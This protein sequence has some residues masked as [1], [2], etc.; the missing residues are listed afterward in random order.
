M[1]FERKGVVGLL[2]GVVLG[3]LVLVAGRGEAGRV[4]VADC[5]V[6]TQAQRCCERVARGEA[7]CTFSAA[8]CSSMTGDGRAAYANACL[9]FLK[10]VQGTWPEPP[11]ECR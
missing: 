6:C 9:T 5:D 11:A 10:A 1:R 2:A 3:G 7:V 4:S 8:K